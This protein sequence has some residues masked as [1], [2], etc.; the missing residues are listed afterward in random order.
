M[1]L[2]EGEPGA[3]DRRWRRWPF[4]GHGAWS[5]FG[6]LLPPW[7]AWAALLAVAS[8][9]GARYWNPLERPTAAKDRLVVAYTLLAGGERGPRPSN[10][11]DRIRIPPDTTEVQ[12]SLTMSRPAAGERFGAELQ[13]IDGGEVTALQSPIVDASSAGATFSVVMKAPP[14]GDYVLRL[15]RIAERESEVVSTTAFRVTRLRSVPPRV[16]P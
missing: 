10:G 14:D 8:V 2:S 9:A 6:S 15:R 4:G 12:L 13:A 1:K 16:T 3:A 7:V 5:V 11:F